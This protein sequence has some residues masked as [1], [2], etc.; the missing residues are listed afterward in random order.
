MKFL[1][2]MNMPRELGRRLATEG[3]EWR[4]VREI[5]MARASDAEIL[6]EARK[7]RDVVVTHD[8]DYGHLLAF[9]GEPEPSVIIFRVRHTHPDILCK[10][11]VSAWGEIEKPLLEG[12]IVMIEDAALRI[13]RLPVVREIPQE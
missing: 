8:L 12:A 2:N 6:A 5:A 10:R 1:L 4:Y 7:H 3:H 13:R 11:L 9:S